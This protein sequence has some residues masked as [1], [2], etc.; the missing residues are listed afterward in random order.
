[1]GDSYDGYDSRLSFQMIRQLSPALIALLLLTACAVPVPPTG[2]PPDSTPPSLEASEPAAGSVDVDTD[3]L[4]FTFSEPVDQ[5]SFQNAFAITPELSAPVEI[6]GSGRSITVKL[7]EELRDAT[8]YRVTLDTGLRDRRSVSLASP[9]TLAFATGTEIDTA[10]LQG[11]MVLATDG[12]PASGVDVLAYAGADSI[13]MAS[14]PLYRTQTGSDGRFALEYVRQDTYFVVGLQDRNRNRSIDVGEWIAVPP[15]EALKADTIDALPMEPWVLANADRQNPAVDRVRAVSDR[16]LELRMS[17]ALFLPLDRPLPDDGDLSLTDSA[18]TRTI[19]VSSLWFRQRHART[20]FAEVDGL[21]PGSWIL[22]GELAVADSAGNDAAPVEA[23]FSIPS[24]LPAADESAFLS[25]TP[26]TLL[27]EPNPPPT[28]SNPRTVW[29]QEQVGF[30]LTRPASDVT[31]S[32]VDSSEQE[33]SLPVRQPDAT[34]YTWDASNA[35]NPYQVRVQIPGVD[36]TYTVWLQT[37]GPRQLGALGIAVDPDSHDPSDVIGRVFLHDGG[38]PL[39]S[40]DLDDDLMLFDDLPGG[41]RGRMLIFVDQD[42]DGTWSPGSLS[43]FLPAEPVRWHTFRE[44]VRPRWDTIAEDTLRF[45]LPSSS[46][47]STENDE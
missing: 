36:S 7:P 23:V 13:S 34:L 4:I 8:T 47:A 18:R 1:M 30:R 25:W 20:L 43:P 22:S 16:E 17:E 44:R 38:D 2:G 39:S 37:A 26:D 6:S 14:G 21:T 35:A 3:R 27:A 45:A 31:I 5:A 46:P 19:P 9:I 29:P 42:G 10:R 24:G 15:V 11:R 33:L 32:F 41:F 28:A 40:T 12:S